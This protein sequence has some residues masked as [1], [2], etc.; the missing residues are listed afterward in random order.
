VEARVSDLPNILSRSWN[1]PVVGCSGGAVPGLRDLQLGV[2]Y[3][4]LLR[5]RE[6]VALSLEEGER[7]RVWDSCQLEGFA[8]V[9]TG[10]N[11]HA[12]RFIGNRCYLV[13]FI[14][15][16]PLFVIDLSQA[17]KPTLL[18]ELIIPGYSDYLHPYD[19]TH[20]IGLGKEAVGASEGDFAWYQ[21]L[22]LSLFDVA[23]SNRHKK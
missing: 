2:P 13:T 14:K 1:E 15:T 18:G 19:E 23:M 6:E 22:K 3:V 9:G 11:F 17:T 7:F 16:D 20:L 4:L 10:E 21:G 12:A 5:V 8:K